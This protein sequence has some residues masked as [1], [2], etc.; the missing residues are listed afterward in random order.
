MPDY[1]EKPIGFVSR[2]LTKAEQNYSQ[3]EKEGLAC[4]Y[5]VKCFHSY[6]FG[7]KFV[8]QTDHQ[9]LTTLFSETKT[10]PVQASSRIQR[11]AVLLASYEYTIVFRSTS[12]HANA[13]AMS[14]LP[15]SE[16]PASTPVPAEVVLLIEK[17]DEAP[18]TSVQIANWTK[19]DPILAQVLQY[20][21]LEW[22][23]RV[24][25]ALRPY[26]NRWLELSTHAGCIL[27]GV[28]VIVPPP[29]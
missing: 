26:W 2:M 17:L 7:H 22:P 13:D 11:W 19:K 12:K 3:V 5:G 28:R 9:P 21:L 20:I 8:L 16:K 14:R 15:L 25:D 27:W 24:D 6:L 4:L 29:G 23:S 1:S 10:I 18:I